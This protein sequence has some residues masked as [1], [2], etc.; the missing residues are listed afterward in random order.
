MREV[1]AA[2]GGA[3]RHYRFHDMPDSEALFRY[4][5]RTLP[6][7]IDPQ[8]DIR[9]ST[10]LAAWNAASYVAQI[11]DSRLSAVMGGDHYLEATR[12]VLRKHGGLWFNDETYIISRRAE[13]G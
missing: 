9:S 8:A 11:E 1:E 13:L 4:H 12:A 6:T 3:A 2:L 10:L 5:I 7:E